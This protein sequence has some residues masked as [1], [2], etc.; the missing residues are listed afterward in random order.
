VNHLVLDSGLEVTGIVE[1]HEGQLARLAGPVLLSR[2]GVATGAPWEGPALVALGAPDLPDRG[3]FSLTLPC[4]TRLDGRHLG[5][6]GVTDLRGTREGRPLDLPGTALLLTARSLPS[7][8]GGPG[9]PEAWHRAFGAAAGTEGEA[10]KRARQRKGEEL[11]PA[12]AA[13]YEEVRAMR[14]AGC[15]APGRLEAIRAELLAYPD[16]WLLTAE[17]QELLPPPATPRT[18]GAPAASVAE[19][20]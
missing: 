7:V 19:R 15:A 20:S 13:L 17:V 1:A 12:L 16:D 10:E 9:D 8:A 11:Q 4:G 14:A 6:G 3:A 2:G 5:G 18:Q